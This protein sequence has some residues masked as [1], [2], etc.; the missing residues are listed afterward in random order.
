MPKTVIVGAGFAGLSAARALLAAGDGDFVVL[1]ARDRVGGRTKAG[2][3]GGVTVDLGGM[4]LAPTQ[5][6]LKALA[7]SYQIKTYPTYLEGEAIFRIAGKERRGQR[8]KLDNLLGLRGGLAYLNARRKLNRLMKPLDCQRPWDHPQAAMLDATTVEQ[9]LTA[10]VGHKLLRAAFRM[11]CNS[12]FCAETSQVSLLFF[13]YYLKSGEGLDVLISSDSGGAQNLMFEGGAHQIST[14]M[15][16]ELGGRLHLETPVRSITWRD[17]HAHVQSDHQA[18]SAQHVII[19]IPPTLL[20]HIH[21]AP[22]LP[23]PKAALHDRLIMGSSIKFWVMYETPFWRTKGLNGTILR[24]DTPATPIMDVSPPGQSQGIL[25]GFFD[26]DHALHYADL[27]MDERQAIALD[28]IAAHLGPQALDPVAYLDHDW[29]GEVWS[30]GCYGAFAPPGVLSHYG[31]FLRP[32]IGP[33]HW[34]GTET[35]DV[36]T[37]YIEGAIRSGERAAAEILVKA[38]LSEH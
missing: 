4:W 11:V 6:Q 32:V 37:G 33:L 12:V 17:G 23:H 15:A 13:L 31:A 21:F 27:T 36:W 10:H 8:E 29:S 3:L 28:T 14:L 30:G 22:A 35:S 38:S 7:A 19:A 9:W 25:V 5:T 16:D 24:D 18:W 2:K 1:E 20:S 26:G 34:A